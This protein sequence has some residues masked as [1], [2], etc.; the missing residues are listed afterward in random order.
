MIRGFGVTRLYLSHVREG[1]SELAS[2]SLQRRLWLASEGPLVGSLDEAVAQTYDDSGLSGVLDSP[3]TDSALGPE[4]VSLLGKLS[5]ALWRARALCRVDG[6]LSVEALISSAEMDE[7]RSLAGS[8][9][10]AVDASEV[11]GGE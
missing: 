6:G 4:A 10:R 1:L 9:L 5:E 2:E 11:S 3:T 8:A 7:V